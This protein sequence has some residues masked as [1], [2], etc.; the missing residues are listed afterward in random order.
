MHDDLRKFGAIFTAYLA[1]VVL[2]A[3]DGTQIVPAF[4]PANFL[5]TFLF[6][7]VLFMGRAKPLT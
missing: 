3:L 6:L 7:V 1:Y 4:T 5:A 2:G